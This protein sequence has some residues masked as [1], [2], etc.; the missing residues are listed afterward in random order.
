MDTRS[1]GYLFPAPRHGMITHESA[2]GKPLPLYVV[3]S[4][5]LG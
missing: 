5:R 4:T 1:S 2:P 3:I